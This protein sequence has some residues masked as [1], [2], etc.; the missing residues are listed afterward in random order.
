MAVSLVPIQS[1]RLPFQLQI[2]EG[3]VFDATEVMDVVTIG[4]PESDYPKI[5]V[6]TRKLGTVQ[7]RSETEELDTLLKLSLTNPR[8]KKVQWQG[9]QTAHEVY[10]EDNRGKQ[11]LTVIGLWMYG[12]THYT[13]VNFE[14]TTAEFPQWEPIFRR[15]MQTFVPLKLDAETLPGRP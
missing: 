10:Y 5:V 6:T 3:W 12:S 13:F 9:A 4:M 11:Q 1:T 8:V 7:P 14:S 15:S 2:P